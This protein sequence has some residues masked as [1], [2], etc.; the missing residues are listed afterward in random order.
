LPPAVTVKSSESFSSGGAGYTTT[1]CAGAAACVPASFFGSCADAIAVVPQ[2]N[3]DTP[4]IVAAR[5]MGG[6]LQE[7]VKWT[8]R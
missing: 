4:R 1:P 3:T 6:F 7:S 8:L 2:T 5:N